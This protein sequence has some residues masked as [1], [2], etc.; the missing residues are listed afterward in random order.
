MST[1][2]ELERGGHVGFFSAG[3]DEGGNRLFGLTMHGRRGT[4][5]VELYPNEVRVVVVELLRRLKGGDEVARIPMG[6]YVDVVDGA[7]Q[8][9]AVIALDRLVNLICGETV[10]PA[11]AGEE[12][13][14]PT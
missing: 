11:S 2:V 13:G 1:G 4:A 14:G 8:A 10:A 7:D 6:A 12:G 5:S 9:W 3:I